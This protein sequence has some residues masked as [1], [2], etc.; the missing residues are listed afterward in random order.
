MR[1]LTAEELGVLEFEATCGPDDV[2]PTYDRGLFDTLALRG[3]LEMY[4]EDDEFDFWRITPAGR[5]A[6]RI[7]R[8]LEA[9]AA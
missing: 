4:A 3:L 5:E 7:A 2:L 6:L 8:L 1:G 9:W